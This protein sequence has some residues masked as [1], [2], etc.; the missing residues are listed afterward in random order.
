[1]TPVQLNNIC[2]LFLR[3]L[4]DQRLPDSVHHLCAKVVL[5]LVD[6]IVVKDTQQSA[7]RTL[8]AVLDAYVDKVTAMA[9][10]QVQLANKISAATKAGKGKI[11]ENVVDAATIEKARPY[12]AA[13]YAVEKPAEALLGE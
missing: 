9:D 5:G 12:G 6:T 4:L 8:K 1:M 2:H 7:A 13:T 10:A 3:H 11:D